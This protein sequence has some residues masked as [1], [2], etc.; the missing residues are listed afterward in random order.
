M[1]EKNIVIN[2]FQR[3]IQII[4]EAFNQQK[5][6]YINIINSMNEKIIFLE[7]QLNKLKKENSIYQNRLQNLQKNIKC[8]SKTICQLKDDEISINEGFFNNNIEDNDK[9]NLN[10]NENY[11]KSMTEKNKPKDYQED[12]NLSKIEMQNLKNNNYKN[13]NFN[14]LNYYT[15][16]NKISVNKKATIYMKAINKILNKQIYKNKKE[17]KSFNNNIVNDDIIKYYE[18]KIG[19]N[20]KLENNKNKDE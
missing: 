1:N 12:N 14:D 10:E 16:A 3:G 7:K 17:S 13:N 18:N 8:I 11:L 20:I 6:Q 4:L 2:E 9:N 15:K 19:T 5:N